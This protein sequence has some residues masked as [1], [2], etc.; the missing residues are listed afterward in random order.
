MN[1]IRKTEPYMQRV[2]ADLFA[3]MEQC[4]DKELLDVA[5]VFNGLVA[6][7]VGQ[8]REAQTRDA[9]NGLMAAAEIIG[10]TADEVLLHR[11][12]RKCR[13]TLVI[14]RYEDELGELS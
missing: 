2:P 5:E 10:K 9:I 14:D 11:T 7:W 4:S 8:A 1:D 3:A 12:L 6:V 13:E